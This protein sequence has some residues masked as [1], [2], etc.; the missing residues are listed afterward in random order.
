MVEARQPSIDVIEDVQGDGVFASQICNN[1]DGESSSSGRE[2]SEFA[3]LTAESNQQYSRTSGDNFYV[4]LL[5]AQRMSN[6][7]AASATEAEAFE[8]ELTIRRRQEQGLKKYYEWLQE[9]SHVK[10]AVV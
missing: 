4:G 1:N 10:R 8:D 7:T 2:R 5:N 6:M 3:V 9:R